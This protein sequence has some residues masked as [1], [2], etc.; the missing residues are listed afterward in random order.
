MRR[1]PVRRVSRADTHR[2][3]PSKYL[4]AS[5][6]VFTRIADDDEHL[7][8]IFEL[9][10]AT[11]ERLLA[12]RGLTPG[13]GL[14]ELLA[15]V[16]HASI[17]NAAFCHPHPLGARFNGP[18]RGAWYAAFEL[19]TAQAEVAFHKSVELAEIGWPDES[20]TY[21]DYLADFTAEFHDLRDARGFQA[22]LAPDSYE[23]SQALAAA[24]LEAGAL[25]MV[26]P[27]VRRRGGTCLVCFRPALVGHVR[28][29]QRWRLT[30]RSGAG[31]TIKRER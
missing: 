14:E 2:L 27:S 12:E 20:V 11:N 17:V 31:P 9:D 8:A 7:A 26:Y 5:D 16:P 23:A 28:R 6:S 21:D 13:I 10:D 29:G 18:D 1:P 24:L 22:C 30:W 15:A 25:G 3:I 4:A 19:D